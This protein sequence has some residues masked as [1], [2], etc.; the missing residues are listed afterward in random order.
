MDLKISLNPTLVVEDAT[1]SNA[2]WG[3]R[4][5]M[6]SFERLEFE[7]DLMPLINGRVRVAK[8]ILIGADIL[9]ETGS[10]GQGNWEFSPPSSGETPA[11]EAPEASDGPVRIPGDDE[12]ASGGGSRDVAFGIDSLIIRDSNFTYRDGATGDETSIQ[13]SRLEGS[14]P[15][16]SS[17]INL[18][19]EAIVDG[20]AIALNGT[21][22]SVDAAMSGPY[23]VD[24]NA[25]AGGAKLIVN[26]KIGDLLTASGIDLNISLRGDELGDLN[27]LAGG[28]IPAL[29]PYKVLLHVGQTGT[30]YEISDLDLEL[31]GSD[32]AGGASVAIGGGRPAITANLTSSK[33]DIPALTGG[34]TPTSAGSASSDG[35][36]VG[37]GGQTDAQPAGGDS[38]YVLTEDPLPFG[39]LDMADADISLTVA[40]LDLDGKLT[41]ENVDLKL[42]LAAGQLNISPI[43]LDLST[44]GHINLWTTVNSAS[45]RP[46]ISIKIDGDGLDYG[47]I[48]SIYGEENSFAGTVDIDADLTAAGISLRQIG[49]SLNGPFLIQGENGTID[50]RWLKLLTGGVSDILGPLFGNKNTAALHCVMLD[51]TAQNGVLT[52]S[53]IALDSEVFTLFGGGIVDL[54]DES[55]DLSFNSGTREAA[56]TSLVP[57]FNVTGTLKDPKVRP[58]VS[59]AI[60]GLAQALGGSI[61]P[62]NV[63]SVFS[64]GT[65][66]ETTSA[67]TSCQRAVEEAETSAAEGPPE[68]IVE[69]VTDS[70]EDAVGT[71]ADTVREGIDRALETGDPGNIEDAAKDAVEGL[72]GLLGR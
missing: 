14:A 17:P 49:S 66:G 23:P 50:N 36:A 28:G 26:G 60:T 5:E 38:R 55:L 27:A 16:K 44:G 61:N 40:A 59:G 39:S 62:E 19:L 15:D 35:A 58:D 57:P 52:A 69:T 42:G 3:S 68:N 63:L 47:N 1:L 34:D 6:V 56:I 48:L 12:P 70:V 18:L 31:A 22:G 43:S 21:I 2:E 32:L 41:A 7:A 9:I 46:P 33:L 45:Q 13:I 8:L 64:G 20:K 29:G 72:K 4:D 53:G 51:T 67:G 71:A 37:S 54:R 11:A 30:T 10:D 24:V 65:G 25:E